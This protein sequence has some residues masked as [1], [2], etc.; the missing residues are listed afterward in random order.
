MNDPDPRQ[1]SDGFDQDA[2]FADI[3]AHLNDEAE[4]ERASIP[5]AEGATTDHEGTDEA[6]AD[7][8]PGEDR[9]HID[10]PPVQ[11]AAG[12][13]LP[14]PTP[15]IW[16]AHEVDDDYEEH[17]EPQPVAP[18]P[19]GDLQFWAILAGMGGGPLLLLYLV[20][21]NREA[22]GFWILTAIAMSVGGFLLLVSRMPGNQDD[23]D[24]ARL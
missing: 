17:F 7:Q 16:R 22:G 8:P 15:Q 9:S 24:G 14:L 12:D 18:L 19:V 1:A 20:L 10:K 3:V 13:S 4:P 21:F 2:I 6:S 11:P 5:W 23:D